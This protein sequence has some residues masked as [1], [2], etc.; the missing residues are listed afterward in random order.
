MLINAAAGGVGVDLI[1]TAWPD[2][3]IPWWAAESLSERF[4]PARV[5]VWLWE[6]A[7]FHAKALTIDGEDKRAIWSASADPVPQHLGS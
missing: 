5:R 6:E 1:T 2:K 4:L 3:I 7:F